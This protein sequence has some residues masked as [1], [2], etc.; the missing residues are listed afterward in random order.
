MSDFEKPDEPMVEVGRYPR[1]SQ[2]RLRALV[3]A[4]GQWAYRL[5]RQGKEWVLFVEAPSH[6]AAL[7][8]L[9][10]FEAEEEA[11]PKPALPPADEKVST[12]SLFV[13]GW[14]LS[15]F[16]MVQKFGPARW[17]QSGVAENKGNGGGRSRR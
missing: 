15:G 3:V 7:R 12:I 5:E 8:E 4:A 16:F 10:A 13:T 11:R 9:A 14:I 6:A 2:A 1:R 17:E